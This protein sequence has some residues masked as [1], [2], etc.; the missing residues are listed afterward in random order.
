MAQMTKVFAIVL[1][2]GSCLAGCATPAAGPGMQMV[3]REQIKAQ[4]LDCLRRGIQYPHNPAVRLQA[5]EAYEQLPGE[6]GLPWVRS[7][8]L[9]E[10]PGVR[11]AACM[12]LG[13]RRDQVA[14]SGPAA[15]ARGRGYERTGGSNLRPAPPGG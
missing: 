2:L 14:H 6:E 9:D 8:L 13:T 1:G 4:A 5:V 12:V 7:A 15:A 3:E 10:H 11:F